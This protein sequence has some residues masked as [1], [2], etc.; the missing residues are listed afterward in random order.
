MNELPADNVDL[1]ALRIDR[2]KKSGAPVRGRKWFHLLWIVVAAL[3]FV[4]YRTTIKSVTPA[5]KIQVARAQL[6]TGSEAA[7]DLVA[8]G[9]VVAQIKAAV[10]SKGTGRLVTLNVEEGD[11]VK[12]GEVLGTLE[13]SDIQ[14][15]L[16]LAKAN[17]RVARADSI[18]AALSCNRQK[19]LIKV[20]ATTQDV[21]DAAVARYDRAI[22]SMEMMRANIRASEVAMEN[23]IIRAPF[24]G[25]VLT[26]NADVGE[27][28]TPYASSSSSKAAVVTIAN[29][30]SLEVEA[31]VSEANI[32]KVKVRQPC[33]IVLDAY[34]GVKYAGFVKKIVPTADRSR[35]TVMTKIAFKSAD[36]RVLPEMSARV[37]FL[38]AEDKRDATLTKPVITVPKTAI[39]TRENGKVVFK[40]I[41]GYVR[42]SPV[43]VGRELG[44]ATEMVSGVVAGDQVVLSPPGGMKTGDKVEIAN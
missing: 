30:S 16:D 9:Y 10:A 41:E 34:P 27:M 11:T 23:T 15:G 38:M 1:S 37:N 42:Q 8:T 12:D 22:A 44:Q 33:E 13:H 18:E 5:T 19:E 7:A 6:L 20:G 28:V 24:D 25:T 36:Y 4:A 35:A 21:V 17:L 31:D 2:K 40:V 39:T 32:Y 43:E 26:K 14:A 29:M 3:L